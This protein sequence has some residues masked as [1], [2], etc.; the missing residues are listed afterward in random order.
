MNELERLISNFEY[1]RRK[2]DTFDDH[3]RYFIEDLLT[4]VKNNE[5]YERGYNDGFNEASEI[6]EMLEI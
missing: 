2:A 5:E 6:L 3:L 1:D 4:I